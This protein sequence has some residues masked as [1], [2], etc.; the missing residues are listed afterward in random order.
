MPIIVIVKG[1]KKVARTL[2]RLGPQ[3]N[4]E[5]MKVADQFMRAVQKSAKLRAPRFTGR[6]A[7][8]I[9]VRKTKKHEITLIV[10]SPYG[11]YQEEGFA[12]H[13]IHSSMSDRMGNMVGALFG[14]YPPAQMFFLVK[15]HTPFV[16][17]A[18]E[19]GIR[20]LPE[21]LTSGTKKA[22]QKARR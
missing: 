5:I 11:M 19:F 12:P 9:K 1:D 4:R 14:V 3:M 17:P 6:L 13:F 21:M 2:A 22:I 8:S 16:K 20:H 18:L 7:E 10:D 15:R